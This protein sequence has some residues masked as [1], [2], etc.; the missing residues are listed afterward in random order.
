MIFPIPLMCRQLHLLPSTLSGRLRAA[1]NVV[2]TR[3]QIPRRVRH[4]NSHHLNSVSRLSDRLPRKD[5]Y[6]KSEREETVVK[7]IDSSG[8]RS[9]SNEKFHGLDKDEQSECKDGS[10]RLSRNMI[11]NGIGRLSESKRMEIQGDIRN[12]R[13]RVQVSSTATD[14]GFPGFLGRQRV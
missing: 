2:N 13:S 6:K 5:G 11:E 9:S 10:K 4:K 14:D 8:V 7:A 3:S 12:P 1:L